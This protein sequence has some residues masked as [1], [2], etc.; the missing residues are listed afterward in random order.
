[1]LAII[2]GIRKQKKAAYHMS[3]SVFALF[4][5]IIIWLVFGQNV[6]LRYI[7][8]QKDKCPFWKRLYNYRYALLAVIIN[9]VLEL[10]FILY[11]AV[12]S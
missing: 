2:K 12:S 5:G 10:A 9:L 7:S 1:M 3:F 6:F 8:A 4:Y 11:K